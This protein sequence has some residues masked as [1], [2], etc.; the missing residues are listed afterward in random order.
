VRGQF[1]HKANAADLELEDFLS[2]HS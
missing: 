2:K 1:T